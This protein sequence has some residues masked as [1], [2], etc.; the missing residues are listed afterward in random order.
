MFYFS[1]KHMQCSLLDPFW[2]ASFIKGH[3]EQTWFDTCGAHM[4]NRPHERSLNHKWLLC[5]PIITAL[6]IPTVG[7]PSTQRSG[8]EWKIHGVCTGR[9]RRLPREGEIL[10]K[11]IVTQHLRFLKFWKRRAD[12]PWSYRRGWSFRLH[13]VSGL[14]TTTVCINFTGSPTEHHS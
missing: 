11:V 14:K 6:N 5:H 12:V 7:S 4:M 13:D 3:L 1:S 10:T 8:P 9:R 2:L